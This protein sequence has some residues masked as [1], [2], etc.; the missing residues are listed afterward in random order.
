[1]GFSR[2]ARGRVSKPAAAVVGDSAPPPALLGPGCVGYFEY[3]L[4]YGTVRPGDCGY[5]LYR[6]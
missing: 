5:L 1:M 2:T 3:V 4:A 6:F